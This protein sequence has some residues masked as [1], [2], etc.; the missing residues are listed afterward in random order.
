[1]MDKSLLRRTW[2]LLEHPLLTRA[3]LLAS[4]AAYLYATLFRLPATPILLSG[5]QLF[6]WMH[7]QRMLHGELP[8]RDF[9]QFTPPGTDLFYFAAFKTLGRRI[10]VLD[11]VVL[12]LGVALCGVCFEIARKILPSALAAL[13][14]LLFVALIYSR[15]LN[16]THHWFSILA[17]MI[18]VTTLMAGI[19]LP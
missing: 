1:D 12:V 16:A 18:A 15:L 8:Y 2:T 3:G 10:W 7:G 9:F 5:D 4:A 6:F 19:D 13:A 14:T 17:I 11:V